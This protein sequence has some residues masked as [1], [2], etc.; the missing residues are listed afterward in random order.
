MYCIT[1][2]FLVLGVS[3][4]GIAVAEYLKS[5]NATCYVYDDSTSDKTRENLEKL[6][7]LGVKVVEKEDLDTII[8]LIDILVISPGVPI[9]HAVAVK[10]KNAGKR[11][12]G[13]LEFGF[14][15]FNPPV[16]AITGTNGKTTT[17]SLL[18]AIFKK[19][20]LSYRTVGNVGIPVTSTLNETDKDTLF[21]AEV[22]SFQLESVSAFDP[23][24]ACV[25][26]I[27]P[28]H[29][30]R[31]YSMDNYIFLKKRIFK[32]QKSSEYTVLNYDDERVRSFSAQTGGK[33]VWVSLKTEVD[34]AYVK[35]DVIYFKGEPVVSVSDLA[36]SGEHNVYNSAFAVA[37]AMLL[38]IGKE[39]IVSALSEFK[40]VKHRLEKVA[41]KDGVVFFN[42]SKATNTASCISALSNMDRPFT[43]ILGGSEKGEKY[44]ELFRKIAESKCKYV[45]LTGASR[46][47]MQKCA[48]NVG[49]EEFTLTDD[50][51]T[52]LS[53]AFKTARSGEAV[54]FSPACASFDRFSGYEERGNAFIKAVNDFVQE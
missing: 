48:R 18:D 54:L 30:E 27:A 14:L 9:N 47:E 20:G 23:H 39:H 24:I 4:S 49:I 3:K 45:V 16:V 25:L 46:Y 38:K 8:D 26:N 43:L 15:R 53:V 11:I 22:S 51:S 41:E 7:D 5:K 6:R 2:S 50:F 40:G 35:D 52:A 32:N 10:C 44:D 21:I 12:M 31:H 36:L 1:Q 37:V 29:L 28:D 17:V 34:G 42:D 33:V 19:A 13:E